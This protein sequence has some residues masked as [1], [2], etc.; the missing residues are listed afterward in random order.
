MIFPTQ[1]PKVEACH[2]AVVVLACEYIFCDLNLLLRILPWP[3]PAVVG[4]LASM[5]MH[6]AVAERESVCVYVCAVS[7]DS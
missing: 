3:H 7:V 5:V 4:R 1:A 2:V 6:R